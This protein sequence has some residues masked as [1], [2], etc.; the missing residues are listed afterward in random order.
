MKTWKINIQKEIL[1]KLIK[2]LKWRDIQTIFLSKQMSSA[3][4]YRR[5]KMAMLKKYLRTLKELQPSSSRTKTKDIPADFNL[6][7][8]SRYVNNLLCPINIRWYSNTAIISHDIVNYIFP[9]SWKAVPWKI[10]PSIN[11]SLSTLTSS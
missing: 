9:F 8:N 3:I 1:T 11:Y 10:K 2:Y 5:K 7:L 6:N 4:K